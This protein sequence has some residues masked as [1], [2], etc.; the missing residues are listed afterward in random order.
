[1]DDLKIRWFK[2]GVH[3]KVKT[4][5]HAQGR[6]VGTWRYVILNEQEEEVSE[7]SCMF[8]PDLRKWNLA[9]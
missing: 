9:C 7:G 8:I 3:L 6:D 5:I 1:M 2:G 4:S